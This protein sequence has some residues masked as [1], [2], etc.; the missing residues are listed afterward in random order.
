MAGI[1]DVQ[2]LKIRTGGGIADAVAK[3]LGAS[4]FVVPAPESFALLKAGSVD[5]VLFLPESVVAFKLETLVEQGTLFQ[6]G[7]YNS[8]FAFF[9]NEARWA[10]PSDERLRR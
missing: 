10:T 4:A 9:M 2:G 6:G 1:N 8:A 7:L 3:A 5:G